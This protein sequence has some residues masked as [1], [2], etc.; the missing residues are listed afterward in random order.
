MRPDCDR[1]VCQDEGCLEAK[2]GQH[3][4]PAVN[5]R[6][7]RRPCE[8]DL[9][10]KQTKSLLGG[11]VQSLNAPTSQPALITVASETM[12]ALRG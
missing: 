12:E 2:E 3:I 6:G 5:S 1:E 8:R 9:Q 4:D 10:N 11:G 7:K